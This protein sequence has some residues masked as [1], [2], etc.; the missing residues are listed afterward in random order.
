MDPKVCPT[1]L[2]A[3]APVIVSPGIGKPS[4]AVGRGPLSGWTSR[5]HVP[6]GQGGGEAA[7]LSHLPP[8]GGGGVS[9]AGGA[10]SSAFSLVGYGLVEVFFYA[11]PL[12]PPKPNPRF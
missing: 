4:A 9:A 7:R 1:L 11:T 3:R 5:P 12:S 10:L 2:R 8:G 6:G